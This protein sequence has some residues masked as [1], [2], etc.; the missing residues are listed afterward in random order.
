MLNAQSNSRTFGEGGEAGPLNTA[1]SFAD[2]ALANFSPHKDRPAKNRSLDAL[3]LE[4]VFPTR[5]G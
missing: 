5:L 1:K 3:L 2:S 4:G